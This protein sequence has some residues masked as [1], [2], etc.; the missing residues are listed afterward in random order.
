MT[1]LNHFVK[2]LP[3]MN[4]FAQMSAKMVSAFGKTQFLKRAGFVMLLSGSFIWASGCKTASQARAGN[5][6]NNAS[7]NV[8]DNAQRVRIMTGQSAPNEETRSIDLSNSKVKAEG[9]SKDGRVQY[10]NS[11][12]DYVVLK[13][14][15]N[16]IIGSAWGVYRGNSLVGQVKVT[17]KQ[18]GEFLIAD[19][20]SG[21]PLVGDSVRPE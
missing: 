2:T 20:M 10:V 5:V 18:M 9:R 13:C 15:A 14:D 1:V 17:P 19:I 3:V 8:S 7:G 16:A 11:E 4:H 21:D 6:S 12:L